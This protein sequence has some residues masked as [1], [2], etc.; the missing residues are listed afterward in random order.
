M[1]FAL[2]LP[3]TLALLLAGPA[4]SDSPLPWSDPAAV[5]TSAAGLDRI[6]QALQRRIDDGSIAGAVSMVAR[7]GRLVHWEAVGYRDLG[8]R[9][10]LERTDIFRICSM[11]KP[12]TSVAVMMLVDAG[13]LTLDEPVSRTLPEFERVRVHAAGELVDPSRPIT[14]RDLLRHTSG[15]TYGLFGDTHVDA[16]YRAANVFSGDL[17]NLVSRDRRAAAAGAS[18]R[19]LELRGLDGRPRPR[20]RGAVRDRRSTRSSPRASSSR[21]EC[22]TRRSSCRRSRRGRF[23]HRVYAPA[24]RR[25]G[26]G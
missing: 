24:G 18:G 20:G 22:G 2:A 25:A 10:P 26:G 4:G 23:H 9:V 3:C 16:L 6:P 5:G 8:N 19:P 14:I 1:R 13:T 7:R 12:V 15:L 17:E 21:W 11:T